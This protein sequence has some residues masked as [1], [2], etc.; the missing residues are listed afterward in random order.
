MLKLLWLGPYKHI[1]HEESMVGTS[2]NDADIDPVAFIPTSETI[3]DI[4]T[5]TSVQIIYGTFSVDPPNL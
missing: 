2:A 5:T 4:D 1:S 3:H